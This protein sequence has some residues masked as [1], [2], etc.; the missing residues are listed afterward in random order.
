MI[1][2]SFTSTWIAFFSGDLTSEQLQSAEK[3]Q[4]G[5]VREHLF[6]VQATIDAIGETLPMEAT[7]VK[8][9]Q[10]RYTARV[11]LTIVPPT[12]A[13]QFSQF[14]TIVHVLDSKGLVEFASRN[15]PSRTRRDMWDQCVAEYPDVVMS[16]YA[17][18]WPEPPPEPVPVRYPE[19]AFVLWCD[20]VVIVKA[21]PDAAEFNRV[22]VTWRDPHDGGTVDRWVDLD[23]IQPY[24]VM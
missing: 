16:P 1:F 24:A 21:W 4:F 15:I 19:G 8:G 6:P 7:W 14:L 2:T 20:R 23:E 5:C 17:Q 22:Q 3:L 18:Q 10:S 11:P 12:I 13:E 9:T